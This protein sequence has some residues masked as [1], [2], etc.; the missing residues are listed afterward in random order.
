MKYITLLLIVALFACK[1]D[2][3]QPTP[4]SE[5]VCAVQKV[6]TPKSIDQNNK[7]YHI[8]N[9][10]YFYINGTQHNILTDVRDTALMRA[11]LAQLPV[12]VEYSF[13]PQEYPILTIKNRPLIY[14]AMF[15]FRDS[16]TTGTIMK[17]YEFT[18]N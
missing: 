13:Y 4:P 11:N 12:A 15:S 9:L 10:N 18:C 17:T 3:P 6:E 7:T 5:P 1:K 16:V 2:D 8:K 14:Q